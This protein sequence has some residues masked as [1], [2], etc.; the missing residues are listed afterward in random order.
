MLHI[1]LD[2]LLQTYVLNIN[3][4]RLIRIT[5]DNLDILLHYKPI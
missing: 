1:N 2:L 5:I 3:H 4:E